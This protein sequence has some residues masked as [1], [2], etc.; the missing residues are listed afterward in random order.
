MS[1]TP[2]TLEAAIEQ[3]LRRIV[4]EEIGTLRAEVNGQ[5]HLVDAE[6]AAKFLS[7]SEDWLYRNAKKLP[8]TRKLGPK[9][10]RFSSMGIQKYLTM[11]KC[12]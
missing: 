10:L 8:F 3:M 12:A 9:M 11:R 6:T 1:E 5:D 7:V 2:T 4:R